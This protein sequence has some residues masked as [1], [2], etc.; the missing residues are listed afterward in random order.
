MCDNDDNFNLDEIYTKLKDKNSAYFDADNLKNKSFY[1][2]IQNPLITV[3]NEMR[4]LSLSMQ[5]LSDLTS[6]L[7]NTSE[8]YNQMNEEDKKLCNITLENIDE[9]NTK[10]DSIYDTYKFLILQYSKVDEQK[11]DAM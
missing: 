6:Y 8:V 9:I 7:K 11:N 5:F 10:L 2:I 1:S 3:F 4:Y